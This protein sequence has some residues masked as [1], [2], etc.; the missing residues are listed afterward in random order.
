MLSFSRGSLRKKRGKKKKK[1][2]GPRSFR[3]TP[4]FPDVG[5]GEGERRQWEAR[6]SRLRRGEKRGKRGKKKRKLTRSCDLF[7]TVK[8]RKKKKGE[9]K[10]EE[11]FFALV[12]YPAYPSIK[13]GRGEERARGSRA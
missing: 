6:G 13:E 11:L 12:D 7:R 3:C 5:K 9:E 2:G 8:K 10:D 1:R 4:S